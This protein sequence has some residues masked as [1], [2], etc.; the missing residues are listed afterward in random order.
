MPLRRLL[1]AGAFQVPVLSY[2]EIAG[3][4]SRI[5]TLGVVTGAHALVA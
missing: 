5:E 3:A 2:T 1:T 4:H